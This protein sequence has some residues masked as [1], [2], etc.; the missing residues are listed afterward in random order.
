MWENYIRQIISSAFDEIYGHKSKNSP[1][2]A[3][4]SNFNAKP[5]FFSLKIGKNPS[6]RRILNAGVI[7]RRC[8]FHFSTTKR[9][10]FQI[11]NFFW[12]EKN[13]INLH[14]EMKIIL[15]PRCSQKIYTCNSFPNSWSCSGPPEKLWLKILKKI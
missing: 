11:F 10:L 5:Q 1:L 9:W 2:F 13:C 14:L 6:K 7:I 3:S 8:F 4:F 12:Q 15:H